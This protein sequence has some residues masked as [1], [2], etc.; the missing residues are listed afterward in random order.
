MAYVGI[1]QGLITEVKNKISIMHQKEQSALGA[2]PTEAI[3]LKGDEPW[4]IEQIWQGHHHLKTVVPESW[5]VKAKKLTIK[6]QIKRAESSFGFSRK[7]EFADP[8]TLPPTCRAYY[9]DVEATV[10]F[11][12]DQALAPEF[13]AV[14]DYH[15]Q[16]TD[17]S[18]RWKKVMESVTTFLN[19][20][21]SLNEALKLW[22]DLR[23]YIPSEFLQ[24]VDKKPEK[25]DPAQSLAAE[26]LN[27]IDVNEVQA[28][29]VI[30]RLS[31][32]QI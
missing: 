21:K 28:A 27:T 15:K 30:A 16:A 13:Q 12:A 10:S 17:A 4:F 3:Q 9:G 31:G 29:A 1:S 11:E 19:K 18:V 26:M 6:F 5:L 2:S 32:A 24:R 7:F 8:I 25:R 23:V 14:V 20:C 22:P